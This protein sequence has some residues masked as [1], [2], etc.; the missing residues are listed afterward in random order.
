M[1]DP[2]FAAPVTN[3]FGLTQGNFNLT[4]A[5]IDGDGDL[6]AFA[7]NG[8]GNTLFFRNGGSAA[9]ASFAAEGNNFGIAYVGPY[10]ASPTF[11]DIDG[12]GDLDAF[13]GDAYGNTHFFRNTGSAT[14]ASFVSQANFGLTAVRGN[15]NPDFADIDGDLDAFVG[16]WY[17][18][19]SFFRN[20]GNAAAPS[21]V[22]EVNNFG[23]SNVGWSADPT[24]AD[25]D[26]DGDLDAFVG[27]KYGN[28]VFF[29]NT[30]SATAP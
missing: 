27:E 20:T 23:L 11:A 13:V 17:G 25:I 24:F 4:F 28:T 5:D 8:S 1:A 30:G 15:A 9:A 19:T 2:V 29:R 26:G 14:A 10:F 7:G 21:F 3:P 6:D 12:D 22:S 18:A 16:A